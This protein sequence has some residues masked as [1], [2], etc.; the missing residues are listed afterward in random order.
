MKQEVAGS[1][2]IEF[3]CHDSTMSA[4]W[5]GQCGVRHTGQAAGSRLQRDG[6]CSRSTNRRG[7]SIL[8]ANETKI[9]DLS[10]ARM[11]S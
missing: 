11:S 8:I 7:A 1:P 10:R 3:A 2:V 9:C 5:G 4:D 6:L